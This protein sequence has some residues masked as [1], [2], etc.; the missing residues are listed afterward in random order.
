MCA[1]NGGN[2]E[3][4]YLSCVVEQEAASAVRVLGITRRETLLADQRS[5]LVTK[6]LHARIIISCSI[7]PSGSLIHSELML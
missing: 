4:L 1:C 6:T 3:L 2:V 7:L 5:L